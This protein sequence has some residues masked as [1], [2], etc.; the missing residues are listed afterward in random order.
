MSLPWERTCEILS[1]VSCG[2]CP[3]HIFPLLIQ[4]IKS[5]LE[6]NHSWI[7]RV[8]LWFVNLEDGLGDPWWIML[9]NIIKNSLIV[10][11]F[12]F[13]TFTLGSWVPTLI[14]QLRSHQPC[15][16]VKKISSEMKSFSSVWL[17][18]TP[19]TI[20]YQVPPSLGF[21]QARVLE[22][23]AISFSRG[24]SWPRDR[25]RVFRIGGRL[26]NLWATREAEK[27]LLLLNKTFLEMSSCGNKLYY[28]V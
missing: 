27:S 25:T 11:W 28:Y 22:W 1:L 2:F 18:A 20:A 6:C 19:R 21:F 12:R 10:Q 16:A 3:M 23:V 8:H 14:G 9:K 26:F 5:N 13:G 4:V 15:R 24:S 17:F 7:L